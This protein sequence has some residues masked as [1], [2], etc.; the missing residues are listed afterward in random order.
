MSIAFDVLVNVGAVPPEG[1][2][3]AEPQVILKAEPAVFLRIILKLVALPLVALLI[4]TEVAFAPW[5]R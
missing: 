1:H 4:V 2:L 5:L 3:K